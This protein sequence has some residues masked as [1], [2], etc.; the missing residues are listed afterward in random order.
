MDRLSQDYENPYG[1]QQAVMGKNMGF[2]VRLGFKCLH[3]DVLVG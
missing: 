1:I 3:Y 2:E